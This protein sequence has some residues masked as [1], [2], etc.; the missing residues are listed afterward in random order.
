VYYVRSSYVKELTAFRIYNRW[1]EEVHNCSCNDMMNGSS[2][3]GWDGTYRGEP[4][5]QAVYTYYVEAVLLNG[6]TVVKRGNVTL[7]R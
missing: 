1:G 2:C 3:C 4:A 7:V 5:P 6:V